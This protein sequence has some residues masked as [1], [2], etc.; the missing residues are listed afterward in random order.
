MG[1]M[2]Q[3]DW[4]RA[5]LQD[6]INWIP[7]KNLVLVEIGSYAGESAEMFAR[8]W[9]FDM[10]FC[11]DPWQSDPNGDDMN[12]YQNMDVVERIFDQL[13]RPYRCIFKHKGTIDTFVGQ[14][15][16]GSLMYKYLIKDH[17][18][19]VYIDGLHTYDGCKHDIEMC[20]KFIKPKFAY[21]GHDYTD[22]IEHVVG[23]KKAVDEMIG[24]PDKTFIDNSWVKLV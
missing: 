22:K 12:S 9:K 20:Q 23:V 2:R 5:G 17:I 7:R 14:L 13:T 6:F 4:L 1:L 15:Q 19:M 21:A 10:I 24:T 8:S 11:I 3:I 16:H 18:D